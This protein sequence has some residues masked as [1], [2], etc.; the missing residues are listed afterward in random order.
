MKRMVRF[1]GVT[2][3][4]NQDKTKKIVAKAV[5]VT[6]GGFGASKQLIKKYR[7]DL[8][9]YVTTNQA[10]LLAMVLR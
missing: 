2:A 6:T 7:P 8:A 5:I 1:T 10:A 4:V 3:K 9:H